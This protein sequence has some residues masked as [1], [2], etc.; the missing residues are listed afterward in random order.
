M[1]LSLTKRSE[2]GIRLML[3]MAG[4]PKGERM[5]AA[6]LAA[7]CE[8]PAGNVPTITSTL[9]RSGLLLCLS[10]RSGGCA[11]ARDP[12]AISM[13]EIIVSLEGRLEISHCL[14]D[15]RRCNDHKPECALH[16]AWSHGLAA[17]VSVLDATSLA[18]AL[19]REKEIA[20]ITARRRTAAGGAST[21]P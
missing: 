5:T 15:S 6:N 3:H 8:I 2:Y 4:L 14:L 18:D 21:G 12:D 13:L 16:A 20:K 19:R 7:A 9:S 17:A 1:H 10:G 11:L